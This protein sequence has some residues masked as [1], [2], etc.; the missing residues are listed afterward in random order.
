MGICLFIPHKF[1]TFY[2]VA[3]WVITDYLVGY[4]QSKHG[5][6]MCFPGRPTV[7]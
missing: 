1:I 2:A 4:E 6:L 5:V 3:G 7:H